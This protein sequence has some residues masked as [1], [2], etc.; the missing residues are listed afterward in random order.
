MVLIRHDHIDLPFVFTLSLETKIAQTSWAYIW[1]GKY[2]HRK[3]KIARNIIQFD[4]VYVLYN[5]TKRCFAF[6]IMNNHTQ[7]I[8]TNLEF[9]EQ[10][11][12]EL[13][14]DF[15]FVGS[16]KISK[17]RIF[18]YLIQVQK[19]QVKEGKRM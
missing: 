5:L 7:G 1:A 2:I 18:Q 3:D 16:P 4:K 19:V 6:I 17:D 13:L 15:S 12:S 9:F 11:G 14:P 10:I 8:S